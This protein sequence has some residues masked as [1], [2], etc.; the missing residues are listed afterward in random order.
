MGLGRVR[1]HRFEGPG[2]GFIEAAR[3]T[4]PDVLIPRLLPGDSFELPAATPSHDPQRASA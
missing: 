2:E 3:H 1:R 4:A